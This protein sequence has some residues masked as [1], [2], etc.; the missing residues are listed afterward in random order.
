[1]KCFLFRALHY[2]CWSS[3]SAN[4]ACIVLTFLPTTTMTFQPR[5]PKLNSPIGSWLNRPSSSSTTMSGAGSAK[6]SPGHKHTFSIDHLQ[7]SSRAG[8]LGSGASVVKTPHDA[9][10]LFMHSPHASVSGP[11]TVTPRTSQDEKPP[12]YGARKFL[13]HPSPCPS[14]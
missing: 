8:P 5:P 12:G 4:A 2:V 9:L 7:D 10:A 1:M 11:Q 6:P 14:N 13:Y 3:K